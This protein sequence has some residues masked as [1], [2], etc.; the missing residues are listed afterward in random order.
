[1]STFSYSKELD[2][3]SVKAY[4]IIEFKCEE[5]G[6]LVQIQKRKFT[7]PLCRKCKLQEKRKNGAYDNVTQKTKK[8]C[9][10]KYKAETVFQSQHFKNKLKANNIEKY[11]VENY[12]ESDDFK[13]KRENTIVEKYGSLD[14]YYKYQNEKSEET[15]KKIISRAKVSF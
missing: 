8:T 4:D 15:F 1:M 3:S 5:C 10:E 2:L 7:K 13:K 12:F 9:L 6:A 11:G 14:N